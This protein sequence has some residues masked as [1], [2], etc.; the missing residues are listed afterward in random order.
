MALGG[1]NRAV[2]KHNRL[3]M[4]HIR[5]THLLSPLFAPQRRLVDS[6]GGVN[7]AVAMAREAAGLKPEDKVTVVELGKARASPAALLSEWG[8]V[9]L[10]GSGRRKRGV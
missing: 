10:V 2:A 5:V 1:V 9:R 8:V 4:N 6:L 3:R 7:R